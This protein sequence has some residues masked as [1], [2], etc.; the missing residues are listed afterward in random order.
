MRVVQTAALH[1]HIHGPSVRLSLMTACNTIFNTV[2]YYYCGC[3]YI[4]YSQIL[5]IYRI[6]GKFGDCP[7]FSIWR[8]LYLADC[9]ETMTQ[10]LVGPILRTVHADYGRSMRTVDGLWTEYA[11]GLRN[12]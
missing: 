10:S 7:D 6:A 2:I 1:G 12:E 4:T 9:P 3:L 11:D 8:V 5:Q